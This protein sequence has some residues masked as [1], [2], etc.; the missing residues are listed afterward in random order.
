MIYTFI[1]IINNKLSKVE[2]T[3]ISALKNRYY[4]IYEVVIP[5]SINQDNKFN[6]SF[7]HKYGKI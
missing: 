2:T 1:F 7:I 4:S 6:L 5:S 3:K